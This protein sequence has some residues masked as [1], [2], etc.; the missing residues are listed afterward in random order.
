MKKENRGCPTEN[1][2]RIT[3]WELV[4]KNYTGEENL[5]KFDLNKNPSGGLILFENKKMADK[6]ENPH[7]DAKQ[8]YTKSPIVLVFATSNRSNAKTKMKVFNN[9]NVDHILTNKLPG[10]PSNAVL[11]EVGVGESFIN[12]YKSKYKL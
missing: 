12:I 5:Y 8:K 7:I 11:L 6:P 1:V 4:S 2:E 9:K 3:K 10:V